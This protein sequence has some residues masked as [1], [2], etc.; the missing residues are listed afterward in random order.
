[1]TTPD[2]GETGEGEGSEDGEIDGPIEPPDLDP[3]AF[4]DPTNIDHMWFPLVP[5]TQLV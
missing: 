1:M 4:S 3:T 2:E 5:G